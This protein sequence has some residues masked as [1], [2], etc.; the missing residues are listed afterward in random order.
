MTKLI[1]TYD[2]LA[3]K[4]FLITGFNRVNVE[5][6]KIKFMGPFSGKSVALERE[7]PINLNRKLNIG[8]LASLRMTINCEND[9]QQKINN[10]EFWWRFR[11]YVHNLETYNFK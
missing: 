11:D 4:H 3:K 2:E 10:D 6:Q 7:M 9:I 8:P 5:I 1:I